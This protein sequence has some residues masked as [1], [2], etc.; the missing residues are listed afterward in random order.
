MGLERH[1]QH[2][3]RGL[4]GRWPIR[5]AN[6]SFRNT[7]RP[8]LSNGRTSIWIAVVGPTAAKPERLIFDI[9]KG[10]LERTEALEKLRAFLKLEGVDRHPVRKQVEAKLTAILEQVEREASGGGS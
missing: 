4:R 9:D 1:H 2:A 8:Y 5:R 10:R 3:Q 7:E 6:Q